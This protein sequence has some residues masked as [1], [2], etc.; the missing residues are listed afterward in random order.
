MKI[1]IVH[2]RH[3]ASR[4][5]SSPLG[6]TLLTACLVGIPAL[7]GGITGYYIASADPASM[8]NQRAAQAWRD[9]LAE[10]QHSVDETR[11]QANEQLQ[12]LTAKIAEM[13]ARLVRL[14]AMGERLVRMSGL[15]KGEFDFS[16]PPAMGG[17]EINAVPFEASP[18]DFLRVMN[19]LSAR[20]D[21]RY[22]QLDTLQGLADHSN[23]SEAAY[24]SGLP[25]LTGWESSAFGYRIDPFTGQTAWHN[26][27]DFAGEYGSD[28]VASAAGVVTWAGDREGYGQLVEIDHGDGYRT[29]YAHN[30][31]LKVK[32]GDIVKK[33]QVISLMGS[34]GRSTGAHVH[35]EVYKNGR[36]VDPASYIHRTYR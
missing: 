34:S 25:V 6:K 5:I 4:S 27:I 19:D 36:A 23:F 35:Y 18:L 22:R 33:G 21:D 14:D 30:S 31:K 29:R 28:I 16:K 32:V 15:N 1:I 10:Q 8:M 2:G 7:L 11:R 12:G 13:Q 24:V 17:P 26:G 3:G 20:I 9:S